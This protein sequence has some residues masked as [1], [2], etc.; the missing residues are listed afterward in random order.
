MNLVRTLIL[1]SVIT[2]AGLGTASAQYGIPK[3]PKALEVGYSYCAA[4]ADFKYE[5]RYFNESSGQFRDTSFT[6]RVNSQTGFGYLLG[7]YWPVMKTGEKS[8][9]AI[10]LTYM[11]N[12]YLWEGNSFSYSSN[13]RTGTSSVG[14]ATIEMGLPIGV[15][16]KYG[17]DATFNKKDRFCASFGAG[18]YP[19]MDL[20][21]Y[22]EIGGFK[23]HLRPYVKAE[24]GFFAGIAFK[25]RGTYVMGNMNYFEY[26]Y[27]QPGDYENTTFQSKGTGMISLVVMP[28]SWK[29]NKD[30]WY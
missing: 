15:D 26:G 25:V 29:F 28:M 6:Q 22:R 17:C 14:S 1:S 2:A 5:S 24:I 30:T 8:R 9:L 11:Y 13:S 20:T 7:Y 4:A 27:D 10:D 23:F 3:G 21:I 16:Y 12:A 18:A 19:S